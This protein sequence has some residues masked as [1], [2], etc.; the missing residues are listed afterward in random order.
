GFG[1]WVNAAGQRELRTSTILTGTN[2]VQ[3]QWTH[4]A[5]TCRTTSTSGSTRTG[6]RRLYV[7]GIKVAESTGTYTPNSALPFLI[8]AADAAGA[9][10][11]TGAIDEVTLHHAPLSPEDVIT[12]RDLRHAFGGNQSPVVTNPGTQNSLLNASVSLPIIASDP[13]ADP[14][15]FNATGLPTGLTISPSSGVI[16]GIVTVAGS[17]NVTVSAS[18]NISTPGTASFVWN[19]S[20]GLTLGALSSTPKPV[21]TAI[22]LTA[23]SSNGVNPRFKWNFG[24]GSP[25]TAWSTNPSTTKT[26]TAPGRYTVT[27][28]ATDETGVIRTRTLFQAVHAVLTSTRPASSSSI[29]F[30][31]LATGND[32]IWC[33]NPD[34]NSVSGFDAVTLTRIAEINVGTSPRALAFAPNGRLWAVNTE[35]GTISIINTST[36][37]VASTVTLARGSRPFGLVFHTGTARAW[38]A[39]EGTNRILRLSITNGSTSAT[40]NLTSPPRHLSISADGGRLY[41]SRFISPPVPGENTATPNLTGRGGEITVISTGTLA[42]EKTILLAPSTAADTETSSRGLPNYLGAAVI[43]PDGLSAWVPSKLDNIQ[44]GIFRDNKPLNH[45]NTVRAIVSRLDLVTQAEH[46]PSRIDIDNAGM[47]SAAAFDPWGMYVFTALE[48]SRDVAILD[49]WSRTEILR[50]PAGRAPQGLV[51]SPDGLRL[52]AHNFMDR[53]VTVHNIASVIQGGNTAPVTTATLNCITTEKLTAQVLQGKKLFYDAKDPRLALQEY[54]SCATCHNDGGHDGRVWDLTGFGEG[55]R[56]TITLKGHGTHGILHWSANFD[57]VQDFEGQ[58]RGLAGGTG[59]ITTGTPNPPM[60]TPNAGRS[61]DLDALA[62]YVKSLTT[63]SNSPSRTST[64]ALSTAATAGQQVFRAQNCA[65]CHSGTN[66]SNN[67]LQNIGTIKPSSGK[68]LNGTLT[69]IDVPTLRGT[70]ATAPYLH[71]GSAATLS[72]AI[73]AHAGVSL[74]ATDLSNLTAFVQSID[75]QPATAPLPFTVALTTPALTVTAPFTVT[76]TFNATTT[77]FIASDVT[78][79]NGTLSNFTG[80]GTTYTF[81]ITPTAVGA[82]TVRVAAG[83]ATDSTALGNLASN[84]LSVN[85]TSTDTTRPTVALTTPS[86]NVTAPFV[87]TATFS[88]VVTGLLANE[89]VVTNGSVTALSTA[90]AV[91]SATITPTTAGSVSVQ[92]PANVAQDAAGNPNTASN[93]LAVTYTPPAVNYGVTGTYYAGKNF[94]TLRFSRVDPQIEFDWSGAPDPQLPA[95]GFSVRW[96]GCIVATTSGTY[97]IVTRSDDGVRL[98]LNGTQRINNWTNHGETWDYATITLTAG[99]PVPFVMEFYENTGGAMARLWWQSATVPFQ[100]IPNANLRINENGMTFAPYPATY[101]E[102]LASG[103]AGTAQSKDSDDVP[104]LMEYALGTSATTGIQE[105]SKGLRLEKTATGKVN[106]VVEVPSTITDLIYSLETST[107]LKTWTPSSLIPVVTTASPG[108]SRVTWNAA[109]ALIRLRVTHTSGQT[110]IGNAIAAQILPLNAGVQTFGLNI[111]RAPIFIAKPSIIAAKVLTF[112]ETVTL[113]PLT[114]AGESYYAEFDTGERI[115]VQSI[116]TNTLTLLTAP[117]ATAG[118]RV[119]IRPHATLG[120]TFDKSYFTAGA[121]PNLADQVLFLVNGSFQPHYLA[122]VGTQKLWAVSGD[123]TLASLDS[124]II[125]PATGVMLRLLSTPAQPFITTGHVR[126]NAFQQPLS[127]GY[128]LFANPWPIPL[129]P[130]TA[131]LTTSSFFASSSQ[132]LADQIQLWKGDATP[133]ASGY[134]GFWFAQLPAQVP[135]WT[136]SGTASLLSQNQTSL[137]LPSHATFI[138]VRPAPASRPAWQ[139]TSP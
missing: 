66:F 132:S 9:S 52:Y 29:A 61:T 137:L 79:T 45:E 138:Q 44:R 93:T 21:N 134:T 75:S 121:A 72:A 103:R 91:W 89:L 60:G 28:T 83:M 15:T 102:W 69:G 7:N 100:A 99:T 125:P 123:A 17:Y 98:W 14:L 118:T 35:S 49:A 11:F 110:A 62:A 114:V 55:L 127:T 40:I 5:A 64:G 31:D 92:V 113:S 46:L 107:D 48:A 37:T 12:L 104:D 47:P 18:D 1:L 2:A 4:L 133:G 126:S 50:F 84:T 3:G 59:L 139:I 58:I 57:E 30:E 109:P 90:G 120:S 130:E 128:Q 54:M 105:A 135:F 16:S 101:A 27:L 115:D 82:V 95:D 33:V 43:S 122:Q 8:G 74:T 67:T 85:F 42:V 106:A 129:T 86:T 119:I 51:T 68:R 6:L 26:Y 96:T 65:A 94:E 88:E 13:E 70:W 32:R 116:G 76:A 81:R 36:F 34:N 71:D 117:T 131:G 56:N 108:L 53:T 41:A 22:A 112:A 77:N 23:T 63:E 97:D 111:T 124:K 87:V 10:A 38:L 19:V 73:T 20:T 39:L 136:P 78:V 24:D 25:E 80:S